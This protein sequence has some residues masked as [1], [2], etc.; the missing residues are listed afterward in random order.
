MAVNEDSEATLSLNDILEDDELREAM[1]VLA[2]SDP[3]KCSYPQVT[4]SN[5]YVQCPRHTLR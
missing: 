1:S 2:G 5:L 3:E 4:K